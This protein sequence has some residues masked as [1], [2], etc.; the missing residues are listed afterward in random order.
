MAFGPRLG[1]VVC[2]PSY[3]HQ[4]DAGPPGGGRASRPKGRGEGFRKLVWL[5]RCQRNFDQEKLFLLLTSVK[6]KNKGSL[7]LN[8][9]RCPTVVDVDLG[10]LFIIQAVSPAWT[11]EFPRG[12]VSDAGI[13]GMRGLLGLVPVLSLAAANA[14]V[15][16]QSAEAP[17]SAPLQQRGP[18]SISDAQR[19]GCQ[20]ITPSPLPPTPRPPHRGGPWCTSLHGGP[21]NSFSCRENLQLLELW[22]GQ[23]PLLSAPPREKGQESGTEN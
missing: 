6:P 19:S 1:A 7:L 21:Q 13:M 8:N 2:R 5:L 11:S 3:L 18:L 9:K 10:P 15:E 16:T 22:F 17:R 23:V 14:H 4:T 12:W 20:R